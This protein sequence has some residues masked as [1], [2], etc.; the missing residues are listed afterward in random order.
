MSLRPSFPTL[1][2]TS[3]Q[4]GVPLGA[5]VEG[6]AAAAINGSIGFAF[7]DSSGNVI[8]PQLDSEGRVRVT[9]QGAS[10]C[11]ADSQSVA[12]NAANTDIV[13]L[14]LALEKTYKSLE[15]LV[16]C[17]RDC[18]FEIV[19]IDDVGVGDVETILGHVVVG[20]GDFTDN[21][22]MV[23]REFN[24]IGNTDVQNLVLRAFNENALSQMRGALSVLELAA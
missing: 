20:P 13:T 23:C 14:V 3:T 8:L 16:S 2:N 18:V 22:S 12:G 15:W 11:I 21:G 19:A 7:K 1:E 6:N 5:R 9:D 17:F 24:T 10:I 4:G